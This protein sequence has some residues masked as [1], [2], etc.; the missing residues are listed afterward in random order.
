MHLLVE[1]SH[2]TVIAQDACSGMYPVIG[3]QEVNDG[4]SIFVYGRW[5]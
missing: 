1:Y 4:Q 2:G 5:I 3:D